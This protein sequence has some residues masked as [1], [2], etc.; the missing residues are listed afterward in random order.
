[1]QI[2]KKQL[3][4]LANLDD[5]QFSQLVYDAI[6]RA[7]GSPAQAKAAMAAAPIVKMK[8]KNANQKDI[9]QITSF[10]GEKNAKDILES[11]GKKEQ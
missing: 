9:Q 7:G 6:I 10:L 3:S 11:Y 2:D 1:M 8:L 5:K 4:S